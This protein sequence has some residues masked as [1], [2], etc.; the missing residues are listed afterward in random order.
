M[1]TLQVTVDGLKLPN[2][3]IIGSGPPGT[4]L[5]VIA[6]AFKEGW[7]AVIAKTISLDSSKVVNVTPRYAKLLANGGSEVIGWENI[8][9]ISD[10][11]FKIWIDEFKKCK[12]LFP[13]GVL[14]AS[15]M[16]EYRKDAWIE[17]VERCQ[18]SGVDGF[19]CNFSC[20]HGL[21]ERKMGSAMGQDCDILAEV[22][23]WVMGA[24]K[25]PVWAKMTPNITHIEDP[26]RA[27][28]RSGC[29][30]ISAINTIRSVMGIN[31]DTLRPEPTVEGHST[32]GGYSSRAVFPV[33]LRMVME[34]ATMMRQ[35]YPGRSLS[36]IG[37]VESGGDAAQFILVGADT[38]QVC[39]G[40]MKFGY[41]C[42]KKMQ[43]DLLAF[44]ERHHFNSP[45]DFKGKSLP[46]FTS[47]F[48]LVQKQ[49]QRKS[50]Q[51]AAAQKKAAG[52]DGEWSGDSFV[53]QSDALSRG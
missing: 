30:G 8:E 39:T 45:A 42:V 44:M 14:I 29:N 47:H 18:E 28:L 17:I 11:P 21:P 25:K 12:D 32:P 13:D 4:N 22:C 34:I 24:A 37:G 49:A 31:L 26:S 6:K 1:A 19:E 9:L 23:G 2:P 36:G 40:V 51:K 52:A 48:D 7:G 16:E 43:E 41:E 20:P 33:A 15:I 10:R 46:Y 35:E 5:N 50:A 3:F 27:A 53:Q 38:V